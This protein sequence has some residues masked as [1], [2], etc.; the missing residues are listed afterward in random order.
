MAGG[1]GELVPA[2]PV[3]FPSEQ[4]GLSALGRVGS[5]TAE[6]VDARALSHGCL[7]QHQAVSHPD[8]AVLRSPQGLCNKGQK[9]S[10]GLQ[11]APW[12]FPPLEVL[13]GLSLTTLS[14]LINAK[15]AVFNVSCP[16]V[17]EL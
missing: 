7:S 8:L 16:V 10:L 3:L 17:L 5:L 15:I 14:Y 4:L 9:R 2:P 1:R 11:L 12:S 13:G 6:E